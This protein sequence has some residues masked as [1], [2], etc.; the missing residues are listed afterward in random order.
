[1]TFRTRR[2]ELP[3]TPLFEVIAAEIVAMVGERGPTDAAKT[4]AVAVHLRQMWNARG[5]A[6]IAKLETEIPN[7]WTV[8]GPADALTRALRTLDRR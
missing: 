7:A 4:A 8:G 2:S 3:E 5:A 1:M 6:D